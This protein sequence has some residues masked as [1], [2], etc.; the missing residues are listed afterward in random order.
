MKNTLLAIAMVGALLVGNYVIVSNAVNK[1]ASQSAFLGSST[2][3]RFTATPIRT[4]GACGSTD[5]VIV[6]T[7]TSRQ[8]LAIVNDSANTIYLAYGVTAIGSQGIRLNASGGTL[9]MDTTALYTGAIHCI[10]SSTSIT[11]I[12][13]A[14]NEQ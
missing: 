1:Q 5:S 3:N 12:T 9:E 4:S 14:N 2:D 6:A 8:Y 11:T 13:Q 7:S 10:A